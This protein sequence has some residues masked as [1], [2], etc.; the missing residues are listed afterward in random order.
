MLALIMAG[1]EGRRLGLGEKPLVTILGKPMI[2]YVIDAF[3]AAGIDVVVAGTP[4][5]PY[6][7]NWCRAQGIDLCR[8]SCSGYIDDLVEAVAAIGESGPLF[9]CGSDMPC[10]TPDT[11]RAVRNE[12]ESSGNDACSVWVPVSAGERLGL[13]PGYRFPVRGI[14]AYPSGLNILLGKRIREVQEEHQILS[15]DPCLAFNVNTREDL[16]RATEFLRARTG[17]P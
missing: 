11:L 7:R 15:E 5:T 6:T 10:L 17:T 1:G 14:L 16:A 13:H 4:K 3:H 2:A 12:Y 9:T 8:S